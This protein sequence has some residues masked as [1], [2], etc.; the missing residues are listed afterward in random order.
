LDSVAI[1]IGAVTGATAG[2]RVAADE[3]RFLDRSR[4]RVCVVADYVT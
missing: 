3:A 1:A 4:T 2:E